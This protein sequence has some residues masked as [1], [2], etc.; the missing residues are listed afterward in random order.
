MGKKY[1]KT[2][3][4][5]HKSIDFYRSFTNDEGIT[6][7]LTHKQLNNN[8]NN[9][10]KIKPTELI[11]V[12]N[13]SVKNNV[14]IIDKVYMYYKEKYNNVIIA[15][16]F[17]EI[18]ID[19]RAIKDDISHSLTKIKAKAF[20][21]IPVVLNK[22]L[23]TDIKNNYKDNENRL[24]IS[25]PV[26]IDNI[27]Y[28]ENVVLRQTCI[29]SENKKT[30]LYLHDIVLIN[31]KDNNNSSFID[32]DLGI[33]GTLAMNTVVNTNISKNI[34]KVKKNKNTA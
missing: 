34:K 18:Y 13:F 28:I 1:D 4:S 32:Q 17:G 31:K 25:A 21:G 20:I 11:D 27:E 14:N 22:G 10:L 24:I 12:A 5:S 33:Q 19:K 6:Y 29:D 26:K 15:Q 16:D 7:K 8:R 9:V 30:R 3:L 2:K 23:I